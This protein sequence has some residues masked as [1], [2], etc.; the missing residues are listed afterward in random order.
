MNRRARH[1][2]ATLLIWGAFGA[3]AWAC[4]VCFRME[5]GPVTEG[6]RAAIVVL[7]GVTTAVLAGFAVFIHGF[8]RRAS[9]LEM[10]RGG[11]EARRSSKSEGGND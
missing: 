1:T 3:T 2:L 6:V 11:G 8:V 9:Y 5:E 7:L 4:P 10:G